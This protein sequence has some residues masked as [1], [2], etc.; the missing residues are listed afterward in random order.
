MVKFFS[1]IIA[2]L[3]C[4]CMRAPT[5]CARQRGPSIITRGECEQGVADRQAYLFV[6]LSFHSA[7]DIIHLN[8]IS[9]L[10]KA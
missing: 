4:V 6:P 3:L 2:A 9:V 1:T 8:N 7:D 5:H 10:N